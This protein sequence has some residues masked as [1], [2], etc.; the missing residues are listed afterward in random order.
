VFSNRL[1]ICYG[2]GVDQLDDP[3]AVLPVAIEA[4]TRA[5]NIIRERAPLV[6]TTKGSVRDM[7]TDV[8]LSVEN[9]I[10]EFLSR[11]SPDTNFLGEEHGLSG[12]A[13]GKP[14]WILDPIDGTANFL[15]RLPLC[16]VS[17]GLIDGTRTVLGVISLPFLDS[18]YYAT[19]GEGAFLN[20]QPI[21]TSPIDRLDAAFV[22][23]GD[24]EVGPEAEEVN[25]IAFAVAEELATSVQ[26]VRMLGSAALDL[27]WVAEG[28]L[29][30]TVI[31][32]NN[33]W[34]TCAGVLIAR[35][36]GATVLDRDGT[37]H[38]LESTATIAFTPSLALELLPLL[39]RVL[40]GWP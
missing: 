33:P 16:A 4:V 12:K 9:A 14:T 10:R 6:V 31:L 11:E 35:E 29:D 40:D 5:A 26:R 27:A 1:S 2:R 15:H 25:R 3:A 13:E 20:N 37:S 32:A 19:E 39:R 23:M 36:A 22:S 28:K 34:D 18:L 30:A 8:D 24:Y 17:L 7:A 38:G 21:T